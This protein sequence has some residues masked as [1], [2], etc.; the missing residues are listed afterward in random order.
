[1]PKLISLYIL[2]GLVLVGMLRLGFWQLSRADQK[3]EILNQLQARASEVPVELQ[4]LIKS[5]GTDLSA[6]R[7]RAVEVSGRYSVDKSV[8]ID[9]QVLD[10]KVGYR[11]L[12]PFM[13]NDSEWWILVDR[14]WLPAGLD[15]SVL[16]RVI[17]QS[18]EHSLVGRLNNLPAKP[19]IWDDQYAVASGQVWQYLP[20]DEYG[21]KMGLKILPLVLELAPDQPAELDQ[22]LI[23]RWAQIDNKWV[24]K[25]KAYAFQW[26]A[27]AA[28]FLIACSVLVVRSSRT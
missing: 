13:P 3:N 19:P 17:T 5:K 7:F 9:N 12:T 21:R 27:M 18:D 15:R 26:F 8:Y 14:G 4:A 16:P 1:M 20:A 28:A 24:A 10:S 23:R 2:A 11:L 22:V 6:E 25:H